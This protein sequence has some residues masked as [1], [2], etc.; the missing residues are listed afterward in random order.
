MTEEQA[1]RLRRLSAIRNRSQAA[2]MREALDGLGS[3]DLDRR[4]ERARGV[5]G[6][7]SSGGTSTSEHHD[8]AL[9]EA[10]SS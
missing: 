3:D 9:A 10:Y 2:L 5:L 1:E 4:V 8:D 7:Y 6:A